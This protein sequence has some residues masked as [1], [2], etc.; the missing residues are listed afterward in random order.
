MTEYGYTQTIRPEMYRDRDCRA[1]HDRRARYAL[2]DMVT[3]DQWVR[4]PIARK[5]QPM[6][7]LWTED[8]PELIPGRWA[9]A[10]MIQMR[11]L[12]ETKDA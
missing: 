4:L 7:W 9:N 2:F 1:W 8:G 12:L 11:W 6:R 5:D 10:D 3:D